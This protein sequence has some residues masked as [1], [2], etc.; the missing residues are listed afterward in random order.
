MS[1]VIK[2]IP[3]EFILET[4][5]SG[6]WT[7]TEKHIQTTKI[8]LIYRDDDFAAEHGSLYGELRVYFDTNTWDTTVN[9]LIYTDRQF[10]DDL[11]GCL[12]VIKL[13]D[14]DVSYSEAG[15]QG[16]NYVSCDVGE[17]FIASWTFNEWAASELPGK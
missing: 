12:E 6:L 10:M 14:S 15:M 2:E 9:G 13:D 11:Q 3:F 8:E 1:E 16:N 5:G 7:A 4:D 17:N